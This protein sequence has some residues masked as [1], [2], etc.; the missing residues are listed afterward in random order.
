MGVIEIGKCYKH[1]DIEIPYVA[2]S[3]EKDGTFM[4]LRVDAL[5]KFAANKVQ[6][7]LPDWWRIS[8][9]YAVRSG[10]TEIDMRDID[11]S[12]VE[13]VKGTIQ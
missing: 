9:G 6:P 10:M 4:M 12:A 3:Q 11:L 2:I 8:E 13:A 1:K 7:C 5:M